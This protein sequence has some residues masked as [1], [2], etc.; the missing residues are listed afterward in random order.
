MAAIIQAEKLIGLLKQADSTGKMYVQVR[1]DHLVLG[2]DPAK[3]SSLIDFSKE[4][5]RQF[6]VTASE[7]A[8]RPSGLNERPTRRTGNHWFELNGKRFDC[9]SLKELLAEV[10]KTL[11]RLKP[12]TLEAL[13]KIKGRSRRIVARDQRQ[14]Y[15]KPHLVNE[16]AENLKNGWYFGTNNSARETNIWIQRAAECAGVKIQTS[17]GDIADLL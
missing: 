12:G 5:I 4:A 6:D 1:E 17:I 3:P 8:I 2:I 9:T 14:L 15:D 16:Y 7:R 10:L 13:S 11:E